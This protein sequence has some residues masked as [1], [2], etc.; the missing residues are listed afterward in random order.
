MKYQLLLK[1]LFILSFLSTPFHFQAQNEMKILKFE[2]K[3]NEFRYSLYADFENVKELNK[4]FEE[5]EQSKPVLKKIESFIKENEYEFM[6]TSSITFQSLKTRLLNL[7]I[8]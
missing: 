4:L 5:S 8:L 6:I 2:K 3:L 7:I 1:T